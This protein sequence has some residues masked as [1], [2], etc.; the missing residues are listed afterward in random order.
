VD[1]QPDPTELQVVT[2]ER[3]ETIS[4]ETVGVF[5][6]ADSETQADVSRTDSSTQTT[7]SSY[8][9][10]WD[11]E[12]RTNRELKQLRDAIRAFE[13]RMTAL[14]GHGEARVEIERL[15]STIR[16]FLAFHRRQIARYL[17]AV[18][19]EGHKSAVKE[20]LRKSSNECIMPILSLM[21]KFK[22][23]NILQTRNRGPLSGYSGLVEQLAETKGYLELIRF[24][25]PCQLLL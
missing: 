14:R 9:R 16:D 3:L 24:I 15:T 22:E 18:V 7:E 6:S 20:E 12:G 10:F 25:E 8:P 13:V 4:S 17:E 11:N 19:Q 5:E 1:L 23:T 2:T 21:D